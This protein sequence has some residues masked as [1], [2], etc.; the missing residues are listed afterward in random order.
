MTV[1]AGLLI[2]GAMSAQAG[3][4][5]YYPI[6]ADIGDLNHDYAFNW[7]IGWTHT[8]EE[9]TGARLTFK[10]IFDYMAEDDILWIN[11][12]N[13]ANPGVVTSYLD[14]Q[15]PSNYFAS[16]DGVL[17]GTWT[18]PIGGPSG[19]SDLTI[20]FDAAAIAAMNIYAADGVF[21]IGL[22]PD[23]HYY[24]TGVTLTV[25][26]IPEPTTMVLF[27]LGMV[28]FGAYRRFRK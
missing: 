24:N 2:F 19:A 16:W 15:N 18:D 28:G 10:S 27:G 26:T 1:V 3:V 21:G 8:S 6:P 7:G 25:T 17:V 12:L 4:Y 11:L 20:N 5:N 13:N 9:I 14:Y 22:D 23:C